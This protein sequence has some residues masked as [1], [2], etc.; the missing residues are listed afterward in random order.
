MD[1]D[2]HMSKQS[3]KHEFKTDF[4]VDLMWLGLDTVTRKKA[5]NG[6]F[7]KT[8]VCIFFI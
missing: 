6:P 8:C 4:T 3:N 2:K 5:A 7:N 1:M